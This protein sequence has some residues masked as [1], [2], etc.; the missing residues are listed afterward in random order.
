MKN[1]RDIAVA[2]VL[3]SAAVIF[4]VLEETTHIEFFLHL[5]AIPLE[6]LL[7]V[8]IIE[9]ILERQTT[10]AKRRQ[11]MFI[12]SLLF[13]SEMRGLFL[14]NF[15]ALKSPAL[16]MSK[17][18][19]ASLEELRRMRR[20]ADRIEYKSPRAMEPVI[21]EYVK[22]RG[23]WLNFLER[24]ITYDFEEIFNDMVNILHFISD[25]TAFKEANPKKLFILEAR[26]KKPVLEKVR[27]VL[28]DG[29]QR[30]LDYAIELKEK[31]PAL[32]EEMM[33]D[34]ESSALLRRT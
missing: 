8:F 6:V 3:L 25:V 10:R 30:F 23:V 18:H 26:K 7:A 17:I 2:I 9:K 22:A 20:E 12:K 31:Q 34:Y 13:R 1:S 21:M 5:A 33:E 28:W 24:A 16:T 11:L 14:A 32:F 27:K 29:V 4:L 15:Q 19:G